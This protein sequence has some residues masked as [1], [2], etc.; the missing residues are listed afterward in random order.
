MRSS[1]R[2]QAKAEKETQLR[3]WYFRDIMTLHYISP[4][5]VHIVNSASFCN[6]LYNST[7]VFSWY[8]VTASSISLIILAFVSPVNRFSFVNPL[9]NKLGI[10][11]LKNTAIVDGTADMLLASVTRN[12]EQKTKNRNI[13]MMAILPSMRF[14][15]PLTGGT[16]FFEFDVPPQMRHNRSYGIAP[17]SRFSS[18]VFHF[19]EIISFTSR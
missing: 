17:C 1:S 16:A 11:P 12:T 3:S 15:S 7:V 2:N 5:P 10:A 18:R 6:R 14:T 13:K 9:K 8:S 19:S 4:K